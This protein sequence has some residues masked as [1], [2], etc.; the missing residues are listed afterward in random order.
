VLSES[1]IGDQMSAL[2]SSTKLSILL[3]LWATPL[4]A[5]Y[6]IR[7]GPAPAAK[8]PQYDIGVG[9]SRLTMNHSGKPTIDLRGADASAT[10]DLNPHW[11]ATV[12]SGYVRA[13]KDAGSGH[14]SYLF[15]VLTGPVF[16][17]AQNDKTRL[18]VRALAGVALVDSAVPVNQ[19]YYRGWLARFSWAAGT[20]IERNLSGPW[21]VRLNVD[22]LRTRFVS[23]T[24]FVQPQN[25]IRLSG[26]LVFRF[27]ARRQTRHI[28]ARP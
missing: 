20:G 23:T 3:L 4:V 28:A 24:A 8:G 13:P 17:P 26:L 27:A 9:Y 6:E 11:G 7:S 22:Y 19:L 14:G 5:Q 21:A 15:S 10:I 2:R 25:D 12:D 1:E 16:V 18:L